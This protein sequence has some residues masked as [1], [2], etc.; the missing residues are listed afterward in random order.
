MHPAMGCLVGL[1]AWLAT[2]G[3]VSWVLQTR[4]G[5]APASTFGVSAF[6]ALFACAAVALCAS[7]LTAW[8]QR[9]ALLSGGAN[10]APADGPGAVLVGTLEP[11]GQ[12]LTA[13]LTGVV[14]VAYAYTVTETRGSGK[15]RFFFKHFRGV[16]LTPSVVVTRAG[17]FKLLT[18]PDLDAP[19]PATTAGERM[20]NFQRHARGTSFTPPDAAAQE[21]RASWS[22]ADGAYRSDV[23]Y[24]TLDAVTL[25][26][27]QLDEHLVPPGAR[28]CVFGRFS[29]EKG[30]LVPST[31]AQAPPR[32]LLGGPDAVAAA[33]GS[34]AR[35]RLILGVLAAAAAAGLGAAF[36][37][38]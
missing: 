17:S 34:T 24:S 10:A 8:R 23:A 29:S 6:V 3:A 26:N 14:C 37:N 4:F 38:G 28:V 25:V 30:G 7:A 2:A 22:D 35:T 15:Q 18:V 13:P 16:G 1:A 31:G 5:Y 32:L 20:A 21:L 11:L 36:L 9:A 19:A 12:V 33:L 27:C